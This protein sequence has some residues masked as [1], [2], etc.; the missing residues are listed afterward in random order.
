MSQTTS[1]SSGKKPMN[2]LFSSSLMS[3]G[4]FDDFLHNTVLLPA[5][6]PAIIETK[7]EQE[8]DQKGEISSFSRFS[9]KLDF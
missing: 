4:N 3:A 6:E 8:F 2:P 5:A 7:P 9:N 1:N